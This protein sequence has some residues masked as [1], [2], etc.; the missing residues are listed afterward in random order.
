M[1]SPAPARARAP[2]FALLA[3]AAT[4]LAVIGLPRD[5][6]NPAESMTAAAA[7]VIW[8]APLFAPSGGRVGALLAWA[9]GAALL[10]I[11]LGAGLAAPRLPSA[12]RIAALALISGALVF[13]VQGI[14]GQAARHVGLERARLGA[15]AVLA[16]LGAAPVWLGPTALDAHGDGLVANGLLAAS[17]LVHLAVAAGADLLRS[18]WFYAHTSLGSMRFD[19]PPPVV[20]AVAYGGAVLG[21]AALIRHRQ[22][23]RT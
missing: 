3:L 23:S 14:V 17:P 20:L 22:E 9:G 18:S 13:V 4:A 1:T 21:M 16:L 7:V 2:A 12:T 19:Y 6:L 10:A 5:G 15:V 8:L 11:A